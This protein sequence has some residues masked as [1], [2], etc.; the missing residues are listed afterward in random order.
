[1]I[2]P[3]DFEKVC[4]RFSIII[5]QV[6]FRT[7]NL[8]VRTNRSISMKIFLDDLFCTTSNIEAFQFTARAVLGS[9]KRRPQGVEM[10]L[11]LRDPVTSL[12]GEKK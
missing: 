5:Y 11:R 8:S 4:K 1:M 10:A 2:I 12:R 9:P 7:K 6:D 3:R